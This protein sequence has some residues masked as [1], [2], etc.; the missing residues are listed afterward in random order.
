MNRAALKIS[1]KRCLLSQPLKDEKEALARGRKDAPQVGD[2][3]RNVDTGL[4]EPG[5][6]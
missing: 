1:L 6:P 5:E 4:G 3:H 2:G